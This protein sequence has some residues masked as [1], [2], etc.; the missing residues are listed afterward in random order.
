MTQRASRARRGVA[1]T[2]VAGAALLAI[3]GCGTTSENA[4]TAGPAKQQDLSQACKGPQGQYTIGVSQANKKEPYRERMDSEIEQF[5]KRVPQFTKVD[6]QDADK[7]NSKQV[8]QVE[9][10]ITQKV[11]LLIISPNESTPLTQVVKKAY[12]ANIPVIVLDRKV[13]GDSYTTWIGA[14][15]VEIGR[16]AGEFISQKLLPQGGP[17]VEIR[18][19]SGST[20]A[21]ERHDGFMQGIQGKN[22]NIVAEGDGGWERD[23]GKQQ[24][25]QML[26]A[27]PEVKVIYSQNDP[28]GEAAKLAAQDAGK[29]DIQVTGIDGLPIESGGIRAVQQGRL[30]ATLVYP[31]GSKEAVET[32]KQILVDCKKDVPKKQTL[33]TELVTKDNAQQVY[34]RLNSQ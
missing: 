6:V 20:P 11:N 32:A 13:D 7:D 2:A 8:Q 3:T 1:G 29:P 24:A 30:A 14:D 15:N 19:L 23:G 25:D 12:D 21:K 18:G 9:S 4:P 27:H 10:F 28:M 22:I 26:K 16:K 17:I 31:T 34:T 5:A 33:P